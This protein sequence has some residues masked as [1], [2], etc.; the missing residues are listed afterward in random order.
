MQ[1]STKDATRCKITSDNPNPLANDKRDNAKRK[2]PKVNKYKNIR[3][4]SVF[5]KKDR[6]KQRNKK[7]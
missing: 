4:F 6:R 2:L 7:K 1:R 3:L 5:I